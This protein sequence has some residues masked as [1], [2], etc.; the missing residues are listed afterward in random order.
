MV[1]TAFTRKAQAMQAAP[2]TAPFA[3]PPVLDAAPAAG[4]AAAQQA[5]SPALTPCEQ[6][7]PHAN[8]HARA[9]SAPAHAG[10][11]GAAA[12]PG[13][14]VA[15]DPAPGA[16]PDMAL[17]A[18]PDLAP[19]TAPGRPTAPYAV[20]SPSKRVR[21]D[22]SDDGG[23]SVDSEDP[24]SPAEVPSQL[25]SGQVCVCVCITSPGLALGQQTASS[26]GH[27]PMGRAWFRGN[28]AYVQHELGAA[29]ASCPAFPGAG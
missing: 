11:C 7:P 16:A 23:L 18:A 14:C 6:A 20:A 22:L 3:P 29:A 27:L 5:P 9:A 24:G 10:P 28:L 13:S 2:P 15:P 21:V 12:A 25:G 1:L 4:V 8:G 26:S 17:G 19:G